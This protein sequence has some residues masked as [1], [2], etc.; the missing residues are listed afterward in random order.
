SVIEFG[1]GDGNQLALAR[2]PQYL[3]FDVSERAVETCRERFRDD[4]SKRFALLNDYAGERAELSLSLDVVYHLIEDDV[5]DSHLRSVFGAA[6]RFV[7]VYS[8]NTDEQSPLQRAHVR[9][10]RFSAWGRGRAA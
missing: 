1:S 6:D 4:T 7:I 5:F 2:Y 9:H 3:G 10:R 8:T